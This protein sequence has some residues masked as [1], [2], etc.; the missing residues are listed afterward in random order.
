[1]TPLSSH[2]EDETWICRLAYLTDI[3]SKL[4]DLNLNLQDNGNNI[5]SMKDKVRAFYRKM[6]VWQGRVKSENLAAISYNAGFP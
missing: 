1:M 2:F 6:L 4:N 5:F 3:L